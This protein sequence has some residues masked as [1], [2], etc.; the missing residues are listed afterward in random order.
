MSHPTRADWEAYLADQVDPATAERLEAHHAAC[1]KCQAVVDELARP[2]APPRPPRPAGAE[3]ADVTSLLRR[4]QIAVATRAAGLRIDGYEVL[5]E[6][7]SGGMG[8]VYRV[9]RRGPTRST[10]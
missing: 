6:L 9:Q 7:G 3:D 10:P 1:L 4:A 5:G 8:V 2:A